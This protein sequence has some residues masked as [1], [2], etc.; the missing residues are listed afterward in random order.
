MKIARF[1]LAGLIAVHA[2]V[3]LFIMTKFFIGSIVPWSIQ[4]HAA[5][6]ENRLMTM[7]PTEAVFIRFAR[8][9]LPIDGHILWLPIADPIV[10]YY[11]YPRRMYF[12]KEYKP[13][14][15]LDIS[16]EFLKERG[17]RYIM[18]DFVNLRMTE[19]PQ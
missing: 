1:L 18:H 6:E 10:N 9:S 2:A 5:P 4:V 8:K 14:D 19:V 15:P 16:P 3:G 7:S 11:I 13:G 12:L 17:I